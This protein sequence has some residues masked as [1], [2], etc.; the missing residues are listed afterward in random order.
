[1]TPGKV[2]YRNRLVELIQYAPLTDTVHPEPIL[3]VPAW[4]MRY[5]ILDLSAQNSMVRYLASQGYTVFMISWKKPD[6]EDHDLTM[7]DYRQLG[8]MAAIEAIQA[9]VPDQKIHATGYCL[10]GTLLAIAAAAIARG[11]DDPFAFLTLLASQVDFTEPGELQLFINESQLAFLDSVMWKQGYL[12]MT[13]HGH[14]RY[15]IRN[16]TENSCV[17]SGAGPH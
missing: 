16:E 13:Q 11:E 10:G 8:V 14:R 1:M 7:E 4:I 6:E 15:N 9:I 5:Y 3:I 2:V 17:N 12:D